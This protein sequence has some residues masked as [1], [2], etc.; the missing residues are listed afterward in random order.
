MMHQRDD[1]AV[2][3]ANEIGG[4]GTVGQTVD[5]QPRVGRRIAQQ[6]FRFGK[7]GRGRVGEAVR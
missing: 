3:P 1:A 4:H 7:V 6:P 5:Q 2:E